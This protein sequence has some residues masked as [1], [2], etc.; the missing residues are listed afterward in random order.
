[1]NANKAHRDKKKTR[2]ELQKNVRSYVEQIIDGT[3]HGT[4]AVQPLTNH[5]KKHQSKTNETCRTLLK[6]QGHTHKRC[7]SMNPF[8]WTCQGWPTSKNLF[9]LALCEHRM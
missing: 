7:S 1:M 8:I 5:L 9:T 3:T 2:W 4:I 6:K